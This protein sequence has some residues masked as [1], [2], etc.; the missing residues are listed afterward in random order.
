MQKIL[1]TIS[2]VL[3]TTVD[4]NTTRASVP[5]WDSLKMLQIVMALDE[6]GYSVPLEKIAKINSVRDILEILSCDSGK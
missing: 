1:E 5:N 2:E 6:I 3:E 4:E